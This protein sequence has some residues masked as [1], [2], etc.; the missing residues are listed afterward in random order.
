M[1]MTPQCVWLARSAMQPTRKWRG[2][3]PHQEKL[4]IAT[5]S[6][7]KNRQK[8]QELGYHKKFLDLFGQI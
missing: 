3:S 5:D 6:I 2:N 7:S 1:R 4:A 8:G